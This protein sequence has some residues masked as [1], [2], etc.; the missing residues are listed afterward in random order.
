MHKC[1]SQLHCKSKALKFRQLAPDKSDSRAADEC[2]KGTISWLTVAKSRRIY[3]SPLH[4]STLLGLLQ[5]PG[6]CRM[7]NSHPAAQLSCMLPAA[8]LY[9][10]Q[11]TG[12][13]ELFS[14]WRR[15]RMCAFHSACAEAFPSDLY[16]ST[17]C[18]T[19][20]APA[21]RTCLPAPCN[22]TSFFEF[23]RM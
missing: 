18:F 17:V 15:S 1:T 14:L 9:S 12:L 2:S 6:M 22:T 23:V 5:D 8:A 10:Y 4:L 13:L 21:G 19:P 3:A 11:R 7:R 20:M 16:Q